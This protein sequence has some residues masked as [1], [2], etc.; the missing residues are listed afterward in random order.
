MSNL[1][2]NN[3]GAT[4]KITNNSNIV[5]NYDNDIISP[6]MINNITSEIDEIRPISIKISSFVRDLP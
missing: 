6:T 5:Y 1:V 4:V 2:L 3:K